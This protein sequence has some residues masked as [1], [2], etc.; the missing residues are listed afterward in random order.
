MSGSFPM[1]ESM[2]IGPPAPSATPSAG[3]RPGQMD[4][5]IPDTMT[6]GKPTTCIIRIGDKDVVDIRIS[7]TSV[8]AAIRICDEMSVQLVDLDGDTFAVRSLSS[9]RQAIEKG[10][11][12]EWKINVTPRQEGTFSLLL[13]VFCH[14]DENTKDVAVL[15]K[16]VRVSADPSLLPHARK[17][18]FMAAGAKSGLLLGK[19]S[20]E[21]W[22]EL[23]MAPFRDDFL[24][25]KYFDVTNIQ[26]NRALE[27]EKPTIVHFSGHG[28]VEGI[29]L[30]NAQGDPQLVS[31]QDM[32]ALFKVLQ[33]DTAHIECVVLN[34]C[35]SRDLAEELS[36]CVPTVIG[37][38]TK[39]GDDKAIQ[40]SEF[41]YRALG[42]RKTYQQAFDLGKGMVSPAAEDGE[43]LL[44]CIVK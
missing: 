26:F 1:M 8:R 44:M 5:D 20:N 41:F 40:F 15:E 42:K 27:Y 25:V 33:T 32:T 36:G 31:R 11:F 22:E 28:S 10:E 7:D 37:T 34:A 19:E 4:Y 43:E 35:L 3:P 29:F 2:E 17:I 30:A 23:L 24:Y 13:K 12:T 18:A 16:S 21:I 38:N 39:I 6:L 9:E 14:F